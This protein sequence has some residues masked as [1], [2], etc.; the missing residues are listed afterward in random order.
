MTIA[1]LLASGAIAT[2]FLTADLAHHPSDAELARIY[3]PI[4]EHL[5]RDFVRKLHALPA[6]D[7]T[8]KV[9]DIMTKEEPVLISEFNVKH[10]S[11]EE[12]ATATLNNPY[13]ALIVRHL[14]KQKKYSVADNLL[15]HIAGTRDLSTDTAKELLYL[16]SAAITP[17]VKETTLDGPMPTTVWK[18]DRRYANFGEQA[19]RCA[20]QIVEDAALS[21]RLEN[22]D[23]LL[24]Y[25]E[26][27]R[28]DGD[29]GD[30][31]RHRLDP[32]VEKLVA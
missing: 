6:R 21:K 14:E 10:R 5:T 9:A 8:I 23:E 12:L 2:Q 25:I 30:P 31:F 29:S 28:A 19:K 15:A 32:L 24:R 4:E 11:N 22:P 16:Y 3:T 20:L 7:L 26:H 13:T 18:E 1:N 27:K 17:R